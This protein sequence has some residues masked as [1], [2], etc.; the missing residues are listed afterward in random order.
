MNANEENFAVAVI[1]AGVFGA[2][3]ALHLRRAGLQVILLDA[4]GAGNSRASSGGESR[5]MRLGYGADEIYTR[6]AMRSFQQWQEFV[7]ETGRLASSTSRPALF[8][9]VG[10]L[11][12]AHEDDLYVLS[13]KETLRQVGATFEEFSRSDL[14][15][16]WPQINFRGISWAILEP[17]SGV[18]MARQLVQAL[19][20][21]AV[22]Q[23]VTYLHEGVAANAL[24]SE[25]G[26]DLNKRSDSPA[27]GRLRNTVLTRTGQRIRAE[28]LVFA[29]GP[30]LP[31]IFPEL[32]GELIHP[33]RQ[34]VFFF[35][36]PAGDRRFAPPA[37][38]VWIDFRELV[39]GIPDLE[40]RGFKIAI[41]RHGP[42]FD[43][44]TGERVASPEGLAEVRR[45]LARRIPLL[46]NAPVVETR[47]CQ[48]ENTW[49]GDFLIDR[50]P[51]LENVWFVGGGSGHGFKH[52]PAVGEYVAELV[53]GKRSNIEPRFTLASKRTTEHRAVY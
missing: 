22:E 19:V 43:P 17:D 47:V 34:E 8:H 52:G 30:W 25:S 14:E 53:T 16:R 51:W 29:C 37:M 4:F 42:P 49:N 48:Y 35:G 32:L 44:D 26:N 39:Y 50:H 20:H 45:A 7:G 6:W 13:T 46:E 41:D 9:P 1:G 36:V 18:L 27:A 31:K 40:G 15:R 24:S 11:W 23:G 33:T 3:T 38:P 28:K 2:W 12:M 5:I 21:R 10:V